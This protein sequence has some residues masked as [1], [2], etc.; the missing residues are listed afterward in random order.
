MPLWES[1]PPDG[2]LISPPICN[3]GYGLTGPTTK[4]T[5]GKGREGED[6]RERKSKGER[7]EKKWKGIWPTQ[8]FG[9]APP[10]GDVVVDD[11]LSLRSV[12]NTKCTRLTLSRTVYRSVVIVLIL[13]S[14]VFVYF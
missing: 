12:T 10:M 4:G 14:F 8:K 3:Y 9:M 6:G 5:E 1:C 2:D 13:Y 7:R 11:S